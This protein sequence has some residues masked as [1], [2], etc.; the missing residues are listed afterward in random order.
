M[1]VMLSLCTLKDMTE[2]LEPYKLP[3]DTPLTTLTRLVN[4]YERTSKLLP[5]MNLGSQ[6]LNQSSQN[7]QSNLEGLNNLFSSKP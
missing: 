2:K 5:S 6:I 3:N 4:Y 1:T 7:I